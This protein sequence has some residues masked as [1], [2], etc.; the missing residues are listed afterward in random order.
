MQTGPLPSVVQ[1]AH[2][3]EGLHGGEAGG[4]G[5]LPAFCSPRLGPGAGLQLP[6]RRV[7]FSGSQ[8][9]TM[10]AALALET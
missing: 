10:W 3:Q 6:P 9:G 4:A 1:L 2:L 8:K 7:T 5:I